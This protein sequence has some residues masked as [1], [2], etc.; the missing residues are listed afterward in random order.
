M[1]KRMNIDLQAAESIG[2]FLHVYNFRAEHLVLHNQ[3]RGL[4]S[5]EG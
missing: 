2:C 1:Y 3:L 4:N 5:G